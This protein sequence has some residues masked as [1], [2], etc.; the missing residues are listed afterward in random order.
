[1]KKIKCNIIVCGP[2]IG[3]TYLAE[4]D[5]RFVDVDGM[6]TD[7]KYNLYNFSKEDKEKGKLNRDEIINNDSTKY[8]IELLKKT[9][10]ENRIAL[11][12]YNAKLINFIK[13]NKYE[14]CLVYADK[15][16][17]EEYAERMKNRGNNSIF[18]EK[19]TNKK[20]WYEFYEKNINDKNPTYKVK[21]ES[22]Q[23]LSDIKDLF[24]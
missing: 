13:E 15:T 17:L 20:S 23:Y 10:S 8:A 4:H 5:S 18:I 16:L 11:L 14:Y 21:L 12:S 9:I 24:I 6:K 2:A 22:G 7:Y 3:K 1:M 19:M